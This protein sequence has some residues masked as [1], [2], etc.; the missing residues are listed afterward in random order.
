[1]GAVPDLLAAFLSQPGSLEQDSLVVP[2]LTGAGPSLRG[3]LWRAR[4][5]I[6]I[7]FWKIIRRSNV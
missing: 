4:A 1:L 7:Q 2:L 6:G 5:M 3:E